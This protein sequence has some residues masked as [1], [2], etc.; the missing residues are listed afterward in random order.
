[1]SVKPTRVHSY[2]MNFY[3]KCVFK[4]H[5]FGNAYQNNYNPSCVLEA[6]IKLQDV[7]NL[8]LVNLAMK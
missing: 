6:E 1:M 3:I 5:V 2:T 4:C 7:V 8:V